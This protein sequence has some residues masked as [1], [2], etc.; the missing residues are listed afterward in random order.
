VSPG[1]APLA[2]V[3]GRVV[4]NVSG[5]RLPAAAALVRST[6]DNANAQPDRPS[7]KKLGPAVAGACAK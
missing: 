1:G 6:H 4:S 7:L 5:S 3:P 2:G